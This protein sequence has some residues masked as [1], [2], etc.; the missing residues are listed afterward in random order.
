MSDYDASCWQL[1]NAWPGPI[2]VSER[3]PEIEGEVLC[4]VD[5]CWQQ[6]G[7]DKD[8]YWLCG[9]PEA[10]YEVSRP[11][12]DRVTHWVALPPD[13]TPAPIAAP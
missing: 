11:L 3:L 5:G 10:G 6:G 8:G 4:L 9:D 12:D 13:P 2:P 1:K 7:W